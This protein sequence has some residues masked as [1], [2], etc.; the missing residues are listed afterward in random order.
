MDVC[1]F[2]PVRF[3]VF[4]FFFELLRFFVELFFFD[5]GF[6]VLLGAAGAAPFTAPGAAGAGGTLIVT[7][8]G[9]GAAGPAP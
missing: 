5:L 1:F 6:V 9:V 2:E 3:L 8:T 4:F 7:N